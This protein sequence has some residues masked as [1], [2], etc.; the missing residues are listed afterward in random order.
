MVVVHV[1]M[2]VPGVLRAVAG[3]GAVADELRV[4]RSERAWRC[5]AAAP[6]GAGWDRA[7][8]TASRSTG[9]ERATRGVRTRLSLPNRT[10]PS[11]ATRPRASD[12]T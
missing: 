2:G 7:L 1:S 8:R 3:R 11:A 12:R 4:E 6:R 9:F 5:R 10:E